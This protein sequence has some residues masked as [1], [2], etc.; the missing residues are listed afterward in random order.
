[1]LKFLAAFTLLFSAGALADDAPLCG[2]NSL[3]DKLQA[4]DKAAYDAVIAEAEATPNGK[5]IFW[6][7]E[8]EGVARPSWLLGTAHVTDPRIH[9]LPPETEAALVGAD[10]A[11]FELAEIADRAR[12]TKAMFRNLRFMAM[13]AGQTL[14]DVIPDEDEALIRNS[15]SLLPGMNRGLDGFQPWVVAAMLSIPACETARQQMG[16]ITFDEE[17]ANR[18]EAAGAT[19]LG[20]ETVDEQLGLFTKMPMDAQ[21]KYLVATAKT[22]AIM[23]DYFETLMRFYVERRIAVLLPMSKR[24]DPGAGSEDA[25]ALMAFFENDMI[26]KR[27]R[28]M[29]ARAAEYIGQG[30]AFIAVGALHLPGKAGVVEL[31]KQA[32]YKVTAVN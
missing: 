2:G 19:I 21:V 23:P 7:I 15:P 20:L 17:L 14:W 10:V 8:K 6:K 26:A 4:E 28:N 11:V 1:M 9:A 24:I 31:L 27:N 32:G 30:N 29:A 13:P 25:A 16:L 5:A 22:S 3:L 18:A 12:M